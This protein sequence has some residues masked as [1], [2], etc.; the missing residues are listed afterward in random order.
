MNHFATYVICCDAISAQHLLMTYLVIV[1]DRAACSKQQST[2]VTTIIWNQTIPF[3]E[4]THPTS[5]HRGKEQLR[6]NPKTPRKRLLHSLRQKHCRRSVR[7]LEIVPRLQK[8]PGNTTTANTHMITARGR[9]PP[10]SA[11][12][13]RKLPVRVR[14][15]NEGPLA[16]QAIPPPWSPRCGT[17]PHQKIMEKKQ[18]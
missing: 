7:R 13:Q 16:L 8:I 11:M 17:M 10:S 15:G 12:T 1:A 6:R 18:F 5:L 2:T 14:R 4:T 9:S 3:I